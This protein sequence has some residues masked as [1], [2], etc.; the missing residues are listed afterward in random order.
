MNINWQDPALLK[1]IEAELLDIAD[2]D[3]VVRVTLFTVDSD[4]LLVHTKISL[5]AE[6]PMRQVSVAIALAERRI[7]RLVP[8]AK[9]IFVTPDVYFDDQLTASTST[10]VTLSYN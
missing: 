7:E 4:T 2:I 8:Q 10:I 6:L 5:P 9:H 1:K 3:R